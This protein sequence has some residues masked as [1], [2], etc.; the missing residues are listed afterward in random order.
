MSNSVMRIRNVYP[1]LDFFHPG[2]QGDKFP[3]ADFKPKNLHLV[4]KYKI[5]DDRIP[6]PVSGFFSIP[7]PGVRKA[8]D[9]GSGSATRVNP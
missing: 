4:F 7:D 3:D 9:P 5:R 1:G 6:D 2:S 8:L